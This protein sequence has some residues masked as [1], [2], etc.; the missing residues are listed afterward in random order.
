[1]GVKAEVVNGKR[2]SRL[3]VLA[4]AACN[5]IKVRSFAS[6]REDHPRRQAPWQSAMCVVVH[7]TVSCQTRELTRQMSVVEI[8]IADLRCLSNGGRR[9]GLCVFVNAVCAGDQCTCETT[10]GRQRRSGVT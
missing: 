2:M 7:R 8:I 5:D 9:V 4:R 6:R 1:M 10:P 3:H